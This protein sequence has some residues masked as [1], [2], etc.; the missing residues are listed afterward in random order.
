MSSTTS[1]FKF[2]D[3]YALHEAMPAP[4]R[5]ARTGIATFQI[6]VLHTKLLQHVVINN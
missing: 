1:F 2:N 6:N 3:L 5:P 4:S